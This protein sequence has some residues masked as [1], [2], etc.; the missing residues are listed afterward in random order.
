MKFRLIII[1]LILSLVFYG[2]SFSQ[3][4][5]RKAI[6]YNTFKYS[7]PNNLNE[8]DGTSALTFDPLKSKLNYPVLAGVGVAYSGIIFAINNYYANTWWKDQKTEFKITHDWKYALW[9]DKLGHFYGTYT[10]SHFFSAGLEAGGVQAETSY[11]LAAAGAL[12]MQTYLEIEDGYGPKW[13]FSPGDVTF[14]FLGATYSVMQYYYP[15]LKNFQPRVSY[16]PSDQYL[17]GEK[18]DLNVADDYQGQKLWLSFR[19]KNLLPENLS[20][21]WPSFLMLSIGYGV[22]DLDGRGGG[23]KN[24]FIGFDLDAEELPLHGP[25]WQFIKNTLNY[26]H[27]PLPGIRI[28]PN[29]AFLVFA[30]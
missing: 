23:T 28:S 3:D 5:T 6:S 14:D 12:A 1:S 18:E 30:Y 9:I 17:N 10:I 27:F 7:V 24:F 2:S 4:S 13:G 15:F 26:L 25:V 8:L 20:E 21:H 16:Y 19:M 22:Q 29:T 11:W